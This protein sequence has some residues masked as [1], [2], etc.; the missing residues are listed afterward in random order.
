[1]Y[2]LSELLK[3]LEKGDRTNEV[4]K[5]VCR[6]KPKKVKRA[7]G[8]G[9]DGNPFFND[10]PSMLQPITTTEITDF[11][12]EQYEEL[13][14]AAQRQAEIE[15]RRAAQAPPPASIRYRSY[16]EEELMRR[17]TT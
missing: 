8:R 3:G 1:M 15:V 5:E 7:I 14:R 4:I 16:D 2:Q 9:M 12:R 13:S 6:K 17:L 10:V 11:Q